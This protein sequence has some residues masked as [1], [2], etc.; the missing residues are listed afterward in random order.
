MQLSD[1]AALQKHIVNYSKTRPVYIEY[2]KAG[3][4][5]KF[6]EQYEAEIAAHQES[7]K[8]FDAL[9]LKKLPTVASLRASYTADLDEKKRAYREYT[10]VRDNMKDLLMAKANVD[11]L[12]DMPERQQEKERDDF[13]R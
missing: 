10:Q 11:R 8:A 9:G 5:R 1:N 6:R 4:S 13:D 12:L 7:K 3:Y 2:R